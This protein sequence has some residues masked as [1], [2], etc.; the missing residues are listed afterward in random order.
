MGN[1]SRSFVYVGQKSHSLPQKEGGLCQS[2][3][4]ETM[5]GNKKPNTVTIATQLAEPII[6]EMGLLL[7]DVRYEKEGSS[8]FLR[9]FI[10]KEGGVTID[11]CEKFSRRMS[12]ILDEADPISQSYYL[13]VSSPGIER[14]LIKDW[15]FAQY[16]GSPVS[17]RFI[18]PVEGVRDFVG[19]LTAYEDGKI[20]VLLEDDVEMTFDKSET[21]FVRLYDDFTT[22]GEE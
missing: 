18:R 1:N 6:Q 8:W 14:D 7:W 9:Y 11:D 17:V 19:E 16:I 3:R 12:D 4:E 20:T 13:E 22:G 5:A 15:H 2:L 21:A 10:D